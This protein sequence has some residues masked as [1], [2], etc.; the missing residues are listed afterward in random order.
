[1]E[2]DLYGE[3]ENASNTDHGSRPMTS[4][5]RTAK[6]LINEMEEEDSQMNRSSN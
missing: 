2:A 4:S 3:M 6:R 5:Q 1:M